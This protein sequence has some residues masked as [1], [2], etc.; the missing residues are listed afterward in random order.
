MENLKPA[1][2]IP[3]PKPKVDEVQDEKEPINFGITAP[4][5]K[6]KNRKPKS[7]TGRVRIPIV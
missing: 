6:K 1:S 5:K 7:K 4:K 2:V 3:E